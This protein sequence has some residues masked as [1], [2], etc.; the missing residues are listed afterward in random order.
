MTVALIENTPRH[1][2]ENWKQDKIDTRT[3]Q[4]K[5]TGW[6]GVVRSD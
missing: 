6:V 5:D 3:K 1:V 2:R 4:A